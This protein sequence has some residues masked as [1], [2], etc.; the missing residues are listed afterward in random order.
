MAS[1]LE[2]VERLRGK[3]GASYEACRDALER[4]DGNLL[5]ALIYLERNG[6]SC[7]V[8]QGGSF[9]TKPKGSAVEDAQRAF[10]QPPPGSKRG[11]TEPEWK[12]WA[13][14]IWDTAVNLL[15][16]STANQLEVWRNDKMMTS[17]PVLILILLVIL[18]FWVTV[19]LIMVGLFMGC[20]YRFVGPDLGRESINDA[21]DN[22]SDTVGDM[23]GQVKKEFHDSKEKAQEKA[24]EKARQTRETVSR[25][26]YKVEQAA[27]KVERKAEHLGRQVDKLAEDLDQMTQRFDHLDK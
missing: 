5:D 6:Q 23:V 12:D 27:Q 10:T 4:T 14:D 15:R 11:R 1:T 24:Q 22:V 16:H 19:P 9:S 2:E 21:M 20:R 8:G 26:E 13:R 18:V 3:S 17:I 7:S 25:Y